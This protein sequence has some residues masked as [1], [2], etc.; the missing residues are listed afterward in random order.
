MMFEI[1]AREALIKAAR[2]KVE[3]LP[4]W[5]LEQAHKRVQ[6]GDLDGAA[7]AYI[8]LSECDS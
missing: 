4:A 5:I 8:L 7:E 6:D 3:G 1:E 2:K